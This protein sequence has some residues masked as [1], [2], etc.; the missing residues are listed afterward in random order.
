MIKY[1]LVYLQ[2]GTFLVMLQSLSQFAFL[3]LD[4]EVAKV[5]LLR[6]Y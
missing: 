2:T 6:F 1:K 4:F 3:S 5:W